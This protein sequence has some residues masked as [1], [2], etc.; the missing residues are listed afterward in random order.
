VEVFV[1][2]EQNVIFGDVIT[3]GIEDSA[4]ITSDG[5]AISGFDGGSTFIKDTDA[6]DSNSCVQKRQ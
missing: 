1:V 3:S 2:R 5:I 6:S 4:P